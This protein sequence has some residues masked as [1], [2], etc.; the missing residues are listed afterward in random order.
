LTKKQ[1]E[2]INH[3]TIVSSA[4]AM[5][6]ESQQQEQKHHQVR[7][8]IIAASCVIVQ[9]MVPVMNAVSMEDVRLL[10]ICILNLAFYV[11]D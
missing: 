5:K 6:P 2:R 8:A 3:K 7:T 1:T 11:V 9:Y 4:S 10:L